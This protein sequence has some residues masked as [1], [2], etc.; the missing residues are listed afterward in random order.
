M[1]QGPQ[2]MATRGLR[3]RQTAPPY[4]GVH[5]S[6]P[7][8]ASSSEPVGPLQGAAA[9]PYPAVSKLITVNLPGVGELSRSY[10]WGGYYTNDV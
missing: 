5:G 1:A 8:S 9:A 6:A 4:G 2:A 7:P 3:W 10:G